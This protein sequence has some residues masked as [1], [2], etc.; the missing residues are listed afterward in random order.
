MSIQEIRTTADQLRLLMDQAMEGLRADLDEF[1]VSASDQ[2]EVIDVQLSSPPMDDVE[3]P[4]PETFHV[5]NPVTPEVFARHLEEVQSAEDAA[6]LVA[7]IAGNAGFKVQLQAAKQ[8]VFRKLVG[9]ER[10][11]V[12]ASVAWQIGR[13]RPAKIG[14][15]VEEIIGRKR[16]KLVQMVSQRQRDPRPLVMIQ[17]GSSRPRQV[18][19]PSALRLV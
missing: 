5:S 4:P 19:A 18:S 7:M 6:K 17:V 2:L 9:Y 1:E 12:E 16:G 3:K 13:N 14:M 11:A 8:V 15:E 10:Q